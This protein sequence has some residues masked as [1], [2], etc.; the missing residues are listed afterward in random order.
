MK[1]QKRG[2]TRN[3]QYAA[4]YLKKENYLPA[5]SNWYNAVISA[6]VKALL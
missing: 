2:S 5:S 3:L 1:K 6:A 4:P